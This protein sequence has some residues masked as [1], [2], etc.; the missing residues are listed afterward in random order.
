MASTK[1]TLMSLAAQIAS[2]AAV[3]QQQLERNKLQGP[4]FAAD[5]PTALPDDPEVQN[6]RMALI[7]AAS[8]LQCLATGPE[9]LMKWQ[10]ITLKHDQFVL[11]FLNQY[12]VFEAVP[13]DSDIPYAE[14]ASKVGVS[15][16]IL[17]RVI[18]HAMTQHIFAETA[19][20]SGRV[21]HTSNSAFVARTP[22]VKSWLG[23]NL[24][25]VT[26]GSVKQVETIR[27][28]GD[29]QEPNESA[30]C[31]AL[32]GGPLEEGKTLFDFFGT[33][34]EGDQKGWRMRR[35]G[36]AM[37]S[38]TQSG[39]HSGHHVHAGLEWD[40]LG[41]ATVVD[42]GGSIGHVSIELAKQHPKLKCIVQDF[43]GLEPQFNATLP[44][45]LR[46]RVTFQAHNF[47]EEQPVKGAD[48]YFMKHILHDW[49]DKYCLKIL[50]AIVPAMKDGSRIV[51]MDGVL[52]PP[53][54][55]PLPMEHLL[56]A[57]DLQMMTALN[58]K[59]RS[60]EE[61]VALFKEADSRLEVKGIVQ[62]PGSAAAVIEVVFHG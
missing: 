46:D 13:L 17:R 10:A 18:R 29:S 3:I 60:H 43:A 42:I 56:T 4:S 62:P 28:Y 45:D 12:R 8:S 48:V 22:L 44:V 34:G 51:V 30:M 15:E 40:A 27:T 31:I 11:D 14:L 54:T 52:P 47:W 16:S 9:D 26:A 23:H 33:D 41:D 37:K 49:S 2:S 19:P 7:E 58:A 39:A 1:S 38:A 55:A 20:G 5:A 59:E 6:A 25:E 21:V 53:G 35:F 36:E 24:E 61:W 32:T 57:L 50:R